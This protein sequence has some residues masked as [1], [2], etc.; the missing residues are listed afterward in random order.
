MNLEYFYV[1]LSGNTPTAL[2]YDPD[3]SARDYVSSVGQSI[4][5]ME[6]NPDDVLAL[7]EEAIIKYKKH[8]EWREE[9]LEK[10]GI[11]KDEED[12]RYP[13]AYAAN[14]ERSV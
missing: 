11:K 10:E 8:L 3:K 12:R 9:K 2:L 4:R 14:V 5:L 13:E 7:I 1:T 6:R